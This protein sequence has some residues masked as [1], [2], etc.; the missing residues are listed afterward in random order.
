MALKFAD[1]AFEIFKKLPDFIQIKTPSYRT[2]CTRG[3]SGYPLT[4]I[5]IAINIHKESLKSWNTDPVTDRLY[6]AS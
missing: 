3:G 6:H 4:G 5:K 1:Q 2:Y